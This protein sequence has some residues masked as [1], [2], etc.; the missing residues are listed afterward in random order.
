MK[1]QVD[2]QVKATNQRADTAAEQVV[3][4]QDDVVKLTALATA[5]KV[6]GQTLKQEAAAA[7]SIAEGLIKS[8]LL[9]LE[10]LSDTVKTL[11]KDMAQQKQ[12]MMRT[13][14][15]LNEVGAGK[16]L[17]D[18]LAELQGRVQSVVDEVEQEEGALGTRL[19]ELRL[20]AA[21]LDANI[22][23]DEDG[24]LAVLP[25]IVTIHRLLFLYDR[26]KDDN[27]AGD[28]SPADDDNSAGDTSPA[29]LPPGSGGGR[30]LDI[31]EEGSPNPG[32]G[33]GSGGGG[34]GGEE[35]AASGRPPLGAPGSTALDYASGWSPVDFEQRQSK[36]RRPTEDEP[37][38][39]ASKKAVMANTA[40]GSNDTI[41]WDRV[42]TDDER[43]VVPA[44]FGGTGGVMNKSP[45]VAKAVLQRL[46][47]KVDRV[48]CVCLGAS[49]R[50]NAATPRGVDATEFSTI[51][52]RLHAHGIPTIGHHIVQ[53]FQQSLGI[54]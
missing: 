53:A 40:F 17:K 9:A 34:G 49:R 7:C 27:S 1:E 13:R 47:F 19:S 22:A 46:D 52:H 25:R 39:R 38:A 16:G 26:E 11:S 15:N 45:D 32:G 44:Y 41:W 37:E 6:D 14:A 21:E 3:Q 20:R 42:L 18:K 28:T 23:A 51:N 35:P 29:A 5:L 4:V 10:T 30:G 50:K 36:A 54:P 48:L 12:E 24:L 31:D 2:S 8:S 43:S 33:A